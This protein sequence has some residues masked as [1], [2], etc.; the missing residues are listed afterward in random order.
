LVIPRQKLKKSGKMFVFYSRDEQ[1]YARGAVRPLFKEY[2][3]EF[4]AVAPESRAV[5]FV[6]F[7]SRVH[8]QSQPDA[9]ADAA[10]GIDGRM[11]H[12][13]ENRNFRLENQV[14]SVYSTFYGIFNRR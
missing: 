13:T 4:G 2:A 14:A 1:G 3:F 12:R 9:H 5:A 11:A 10:T 7:F 6:N 8:T